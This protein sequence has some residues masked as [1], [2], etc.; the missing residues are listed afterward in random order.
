M[1]ASICN[2]TASDIQSI[3][4]KPLMA[5]HKPLIFN[6]PPTK[7]RGK[8]LLWGRVYNIPV[9]DFSPW[10]KHSMGSFPGKGLLWW[11]SYYATPVSQF[12]KNWIL[13]LVQLHVI[14][15][16]GCSATHLRTVCFIFDNF[17]EQIITTNLKCSCYFINYLTLAIPRRFREFTNYTSL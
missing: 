16:E 9:V 1:C 6:P 8:N 7:P 5:F 3:D 17:R 12:T 13:R 4:L 11:E 14:V 10:E 2:L 15:L